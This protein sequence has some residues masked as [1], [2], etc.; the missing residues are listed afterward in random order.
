MSLLTIALLVGFLVSTVLL[1]V[2]LLYLFKW[3]KSG[4]KNPVNLKN[5]GQSFM[6]IFFSK[7]FKVFLV[8]TLALISIFCLSMFI[9]EMTK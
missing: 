7:W 6:A 2:Y 3:S 4:I 1:V 5:S 8:F 9:V